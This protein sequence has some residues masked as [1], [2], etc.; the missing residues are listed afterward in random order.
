MQN[1]KN[2]ATIVV[3]FEVIQKTLKSNDGMDL[4]KVTGSSV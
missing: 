1:S 4:K 3:Q 2:G